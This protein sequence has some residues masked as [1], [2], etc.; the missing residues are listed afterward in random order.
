MKLGSTRGPKSVKQSFRSCLAYHEEAP[1][2][3]PVAKEHEDARKTVGHLTVFIVMQ[4]YENGRI[5]RREVGDLL[6]KNFLH[7]RLTFLHCNTGK[8]MTPIIGEQGGSML[9]HKLPV[10]ELGQA[11]VRDVVLLKDP[12]NLDKYLVRRLVAVEGYEM[13]STDE[14]DEPFVL[15][16]EQCRVLSENKSLNPQEAYD[17]RTFGPVPMSNIVGRVMYCL[18]TSTDHGPVPNSRDGM[19][20]DSA[21]LEV[22]LDVD[23]MAKNAKT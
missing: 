5:T 15:E 16:K 2:K 23:E 10:A 14:K 1:M 19:R 8:E 17:S 21:I 3:T 6:W 22:G 7:A 11:F 20:M 12:Q 9:V 4:E 13:A 18:R